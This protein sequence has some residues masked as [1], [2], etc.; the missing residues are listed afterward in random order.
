MEQVRSAATI[1]DVAA[2]AGVSTATVSRVLASGAW[3]RPDTRRRVLAAA[4][5]LDYRPSGVARSLKLRTT[6]TLGLLITDIQNPFYAHL[7]RSIDDAARV[8]GFALLLGN[9]AENAEREAAYLELLA[10]RRVDGLIIAAT[11]LT[12][13]HRRWLRHSPVP[14]V[15]VNCALPTARVPAILSDNRAGALAATRHLLGLGHCAIGHLAGDLANPAAAER[16]AGV[17]EALGEA[18]LDPAALAI[19]ESDGHVAGGERAMKKL[20]RRARSTTGVICFNDL[21]AVGALRALRTEGCRVPQDVSVV[22]FDDID[23]AAYVQPALTTVRQPLAEMGRWAV[24]TLAQRLRSPT[25]NG[26]EADPFE[27]APTVRLPV[28]LVVRESTGPA[29]ADRTRRAAA[30]SAV[31]RAP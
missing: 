11:S 22:G 24:E 30:A 23:L 2:R 19:S 7:V 29:P 25:G 15:L 17:R 12:A 26:P 13:R 27:A 5:E 4:R 18:G 9:G 20:L 1:A 28:R 10:S 31:S 8:H 16:L 3:G 6:D 14:L 21:T